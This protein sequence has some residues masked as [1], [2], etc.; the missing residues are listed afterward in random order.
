MISTLF[1]PIQGHP[2]DRGLSEGL[3]EAI[4]TGQMNSVYP[5]YGAKPSL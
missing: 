2:D 4:N 3:Q 1:P 5:F